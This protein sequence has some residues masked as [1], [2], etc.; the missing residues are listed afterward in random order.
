MTLEAGDTGSN[1]MSVLSKQPASS[2]LLR[3]KMPGNDSS[4]VCC[5][6]SR[7]E[8][9]CPPLKMFP[10]QVPVCL[11]PPASEATTVLTGSFA[12]SPLPS[13]PWGFVSGPKNGHEEDMTHSNTSQTMLNNGGWDHCEFTSTCEQSIVWVQLPEQGPQAPWVPNYSIVQ[14]HLLTFTSLLL[15]VHVCVFVFQGRDMPMWKNP[16]T[17]RGETGGQMNYWDGGRS[18][19]I[20]KLIHTQTSRVHYHPARLLNYPSWTRTVSK[21]YIA[22]SAY[23]IKCVSEACLTACLYFAKKM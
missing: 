20:T 5:A 21:F 13:A 9:F 17:C 19:K 16:T 11:F 1:L 3:E 2:L 10:P 12:P 7:I 8:A 15:C 6:A 14:V 18:Q 23:L 4:L 22:D